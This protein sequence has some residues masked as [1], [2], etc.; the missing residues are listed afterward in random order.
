MPGDIP[1]WGQAGSFSE[2][3]DTEACGKACQEVPRCRSY[4][5]SATDVFAV[6]M[7]SSIFQAG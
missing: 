6:D 7:L 2:I 3:A 4:E 5:Y 1:G